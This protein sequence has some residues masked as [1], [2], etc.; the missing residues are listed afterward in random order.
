MVSTCSQDDG[1]DVGLHMASRGLPEPVQVKGR[2]DVCL[3]Q[4]LPRRFSWELPARNDLVNVVAGLVALLIGSLV[5][6]L[7]VVIDTIIH[8]WHNLF[9]KEGPAGSDVGF[10]T[11]HLSLQLIVVSGAWASRPPF[12]T[13]ITFYFAELPTVLLTLDGTLMGLRVPWRCEVQVAPQTRGP[14]EPSSFGNTQLPHESLVD[15]FSILFSPTIGMLGSL[16]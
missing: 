8:G 9:G 10:T 4:I 2:L 11:A 14:V 13:G 15:G 16:T 12:F 1:H 5:R 3:Q 6:W 7:F